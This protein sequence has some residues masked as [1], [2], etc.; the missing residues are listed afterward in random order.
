MRYTSEG[1]SG[2]PSKLMDELSMVIEIL[3]AEDK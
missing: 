2:S 1:Y 3:K